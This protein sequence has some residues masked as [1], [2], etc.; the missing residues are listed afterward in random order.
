MKLNKLKLNNI[1]I[2]SKF[3]MLL[4]LI[5]LLPSIGL[6]FLI[7]ITV[8][9]IVEKKESE[10]T[11]QLIEQVNNSLELHLENMQKVTYLI[12]YNPK[13]KSFFESEENDTYEIKQFLRGFTA[14]SPEI[15]SILIVNN[16]GEYISNE[17]Y[18]Q[19]IKSLTEEDWYE[20]AVLNKGI[21]TL[22]GHP[23]NRNLVS[24]SKY[25]NDELITGVR[26]IIDPNTQEV[27]GVILIDLKTR[28]VSEVINKIQLNKTGFLMVIDDDENIIYVPDN[29]IKN[30]QNIRIDENTIEPISENVNIQYLYRKSSF[31]NWSTVGVFQKD[32]LLLESLQVYF[33]VCSYLFVIVLFGVAASFYL[34]K[35]I[36][37][38]VNNLKNIMNKVEYGDLSVRYTDSRQDEIGMLGKSFNNMIVQ[39]NSLIDINEMQAKQ[40]RE[41][42]LEALQAQIK[43]HFLYNTLDTINWM[44]RKNNIHEVA[45]IVNDLS[46]IFRI[47]LSKGR[48]KILIQEEI[49][50][51]HSYMRI[52]K[53]RYGE[54]LDYQINLDPKL[55]DYQIV[56]LTLQPIV[57]NAIYHGIKEKRGSGFISI[58]IEEKDGNIQLQVKD[59]GKGILPE[60]LK[61]LENSLFSIGQ[62]VKYIGSGKSKSYGMLNVQARLKLT[63][64]ELF[65]ISIE[66]EYNVGTTVNIVVPIEQNIMME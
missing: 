48:E 24:L 64:G 54:K 52:Q 41:A 32:D 26:S 46:Q 21:F 15:A 9:Q 51:I 7:S 61:D 4:L 11:L 53:V 66:S 57:E 59:N 10:N 8:D 12:S 45:D 25:N 60:K 56:K 44:A 2:R 62:D 36:S 22:L 55:K 13:V 38:P 43:P 63:Y 34:S 14:T 35:A 27:Q 1:S 16:K 42:E 40:K 30:Y 39:I 49:E 37:N 20:E 19:N 58:I 33:F 23:K 6:G 31:G 5:S 65:G 29:D 18:P 50:H 3:I 17:L 28:L 47:G